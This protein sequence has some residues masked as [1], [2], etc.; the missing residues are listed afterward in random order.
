MVQ[1]AV[2]LR[3]ARACTYIAT[4]VGLAG[5][6]SPETRPLV[7]RVTPVYLLLL[8]GLLLVWLPWARPIGPTLGAIVFVM[9]FGFGLEVAGVQTGEVFGGPYTYGEMMG[10]SA[11][12]V[13]FVIAFNW[14]LLTYL[15]LELARQMTRK[16]GARAL[17]A[18]GIIV[19][20]DLIL[21]PVAINLGFWSWPDNR[22]PAQNFLVWGIAGMLLAVILERA[23]PQ[24]RHPMAQTLLLNLLLFFAGIHLATGVL[25]FSFN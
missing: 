14:L 5:L 9:L 19:G 18:A 2:T 21:E 24:Q 3:W 1:S 25:G 11:W 6:L 16:P 20:L 15:S 8:N 10:P 12:G 22:P 17:V 4:V 23:L 13:P 7:L